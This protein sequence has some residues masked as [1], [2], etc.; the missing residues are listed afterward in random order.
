MRIQFTL[1]LTSSAAAALSKTM[2]RV[3]KQ[4]SL[5]SLAGL[6]RRTVCHSGAQEVY[7]DLLTRLADTSRFHASG[8]YGHRG[9]FLASLASLSLLTI[10]SRHIHQQTVSS[11]LFH[12]SEAVARLIPAPA[13][14]SLRFADH[15][16]CVSVNNLFGNMPVRVKSRAASLENPDE[17]ER[18]WDSLRYALV[19][20]ML[21]NSQLRKLVISDKERG[22][23]ISVR[24]GPTGRDPSAT[25][26]ADE[27]D[28]MRV[29]SILAQSGMTATRNMD[30]WHIVSATLPDLLIRA[31]IS[32]I[33]SPSK[34]LQFISLGDNPI[35]SRSN[36]NV[37]F[38]E[39]NRLMASSDFGNSGVISGG[40]SS[41][42]FEDMENASDRGWAKSVCKWPMFYIR[43]DTR[44]ARTLS[45]VGDEL[46]PDSEKSIQRIS[47]VLG[48]LIVEFLKQQNMRPRITR[49]QGKMLNRGQQA[50][51]T[52]TISQ[53][54]AGQSV[55][56]LGR[57]GN[58]RST[59]EAFSNQLKLP[60]FQRS[61]STTPGPS[62]KSWSRVKAAKDPEHLQATDNRNLA[63]TSDRELKYQEPRSQIRGHSSRKHR[64][65]HSMQLSQTHEEPIP[66]TE[67]NH[68]DL[69]VVE[70]RTA[71]MS[72]DNLIPWTDPRTGKTHMINPR[73]GQTVDRKASDTG[74][75]I[76]PGSFAGASRQIGHVQNP[77]N[78]S[79]SAWVDELLTSWDNPTFNR[80]EK[81][82]S[83]L[84]VGSN[85]L[86][87]NGA[88]GCPHDIGTLSTAQVAKFRGKLQR[89]CLATSRVIAQV[90][91]KF[92]L[93]KVRA[94]P[95]QLAGKE[96]E[97]A[98]VL[99]DQH[100]ADE[101]CRVEQ[102]F[103]EMFAPA[104]TPNDIARVR[105]LEIDPISFSVSA[106]EGTLFQMYLDFFATWG[107]RYEVATKPA[108]GVV[109]SVKALPLLIAE[110]CRL[111]SNVLIDLLRRE[112]WTSEE[113]DGR[114]LKT[115]S[116]H[117]ISSNNSALIGE[118]QS[119]FV[120]TTETTGS[121]PS[122]IQHMSG[123]PQGILDLL[124]SRACRGAIMFNDPLSIEECQ[125]LVS[126]LAQCAFP[127][128]CAHGR[129]S[130][131]PIL[132]LRSNAE[133]DD[134][135]ASGA[136]TIMPGDVDEHNDSDLDFLEA[137]RTRYVQ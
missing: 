86:D 23:R 118:D 80:T 19:S 37:L 6:G 56:R 89:Y 10:I 83:K 15:G 102:L 112:V 131:V 65:T 58:G 33:P 28:L 95:E 12:Q 88:H 87:I 22:K 99:V 78:V 100:A 50:T 73:T 60:S 14:H 27:V 117:Q 40:A 20:L 1:Q 104:E 137:F 63:A 2:A 9:L 108:S 119:L 46:S 116:K 31:A 52:S 94:A 54:S 16:T 75:R 3:S 120:E 34:K 72:G 18:E 13:H 134:P 53:R 82:V 70:D 47:D 32:T 55:A 74:F 7:F 42:R 59:E 76:W 67:G 43:I 11:V 107:I 90:D 136:G 41:T 106:T 51:T 68:R 81:Q 45:V 29:G 123:C 93:V 38:H 5:N 115:T 49:R 64:T 8:A 109:V 126:R 66:S 110:R 91:H 62:F 128:Q 24:L 36:S 121:A 125:A 69:D 132:D 127:F 48:A 113:D 61:C 79:S 92:I 25:N 103:E 98:L 130:M 30:S 97:S 105:T 129:P 84:D 39:I 21:A 101:R 44:S 57:D 122:W 17:L 4:P 71:A 35:L 133:G 111:E 26:G 77:S 96:L 135:L 124:S 114:L 85:Y